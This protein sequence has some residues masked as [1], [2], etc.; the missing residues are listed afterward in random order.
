MHTNEKYI[1]VNHDSCRR[2]PFRKFLKYLYMCLCI[3]NIEKCKLCRGLLQLSFIYLFCFFFSIIFSH[4]TFLC[5]IFD[6]I[7][8]CMW[9]YA[10]Y[11]SI[12]F[13][14]EH[15]TLINSYICNM[16]IRTHIYI[17]IC[18]AYQKNTIFLLA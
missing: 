6:W 15:F 12:I 13:S 9:N 4:L 16:Y 11:R 2:R 14:R 3:S 18:I 8:H 10:N 1:T 7:A 17:Y 5:L